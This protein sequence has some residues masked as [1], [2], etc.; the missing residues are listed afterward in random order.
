[1]STCRPPWARPSK[2]KPAK[3]ETNASAKTAGDTK[4]EPI[5]I[6]TASAAELES[7]KGIGEATAKMIIDG[8]PDKA[9]DELVTKKIMS[10]G[11]YDKIK[12]QIVAKRAPAPVATTSPASPKSAESAKTAAATTESSA[13]ATTESKPVPAKGMVWVNR[14]AGTLSSEPISTHRGR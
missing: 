11:V 3:S 13:K 10:K 4:K 6:N 2:D 9:K 8:R 7:V 1:L 5:D 14:R 12:D